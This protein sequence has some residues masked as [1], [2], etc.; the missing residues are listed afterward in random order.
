MIPIIFLSFYTQVITNYTVFKTIN[1][2]N[3]PLDQLFLVYF[4]GI[5]QSIFVFFAFH[6]ASK[7]TEKGKQM[8]LIITKV[9]NN[10]EDY[11]VINQV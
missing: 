8:S 1:A 9:I 4:W 7:T 10:S 5:F 11:E 2:K 6:F 3:I